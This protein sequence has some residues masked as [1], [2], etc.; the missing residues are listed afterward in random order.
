[1]NAKEEVAR[2]MQDAQELLDKLI[3]TPGEFT[4]RFGVLCGAMMAFLEELRGSQP[5]TYNQVQIMAQKTAKELICPTYDL[6]PDL[7]NRKLHS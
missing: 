5:E 2:G 6:R 4:I 3:D 1:M 7:L